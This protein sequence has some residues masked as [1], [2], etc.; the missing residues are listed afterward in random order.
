MKGVEKESRQVVTAPKIC[1]VCSGTGVT[2]GVCMA[3][4]CIECDGIGWLPTP[5]QDLTQQ[6]GWMLTKTNQR[7]RLYAARESTFGPEED[8]RDKGSNGHRGNWT[9]D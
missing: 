9:G 8:Y 6:L 5:G 4:I 2:R 1:A 3:L 7:L